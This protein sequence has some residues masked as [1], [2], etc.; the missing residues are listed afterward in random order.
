MQGFSDQKLK[1]SRVFLISI[2]HTISYITGKKM[3]FPVSLLLSFSP[4]GFPLVFSPLSLSSPRPPSITISSYLIPL[5]LTPYF[6][7]LFL[8]PCAKEAK[9]RPSLTKFAWSDPKFAFFLSTIVII[10]NYL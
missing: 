2:K 7:F 1:I 8:F 9:V 4:C 3:I 10:I 6:L 5:F